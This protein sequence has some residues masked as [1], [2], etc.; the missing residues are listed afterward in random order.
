MNNLPSARRPQYIVAPENCM[1]CG[2][3]AN[4][5]S[6]DAIHMEW[7]AEGFLIPK[8]NTESCIN[9]GLCAKQ[10]IA[11]EEKPAYTDDIE[12]VASW[13]GWNKH[14][15]THLQSSSGGIFTALAE[16]V[17]F[18]GGCVF[19]VVWQDKYTAAF[20]KAE[21]IEELAKMRGSK[22]T[23]AIPG[24]VYQEVLAELKTGRQVLFSGTPCQVH[25]L[26]KFLRKPY[27]N[28]LIIDI[29]CHGVPSR[30][31]LEKYIQE[32]ENRMGKMVAYISFRDKSAGWLRYHVTCHYTDGSTSSTPM[33]KDLYMRLFLCDK[34][35]NLACYNCPYA[36]IPR[37]GD[38]T[39]GDY[40]GVQKIH[41]DWPIDRGISAILANSAKGIQSLQQLSDKLT[42]CEEPFDKIYS[43]QPVVY[44]RHEQQVPR[45]R[46]MVLAR[47]PFWPLEKALHK[48]VN[49]V[50]IG[51]I[52]LKRNGFLHKLLRKC[53][54]LISR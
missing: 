33:D 2:L 14:E 18:A 26:K 16:H 23:P 44:V 43:G 35:L 11:L 24:K 47:L 4:V 38:I 50:R 46:P 37:Q 42:L 20:S 31:I 52:Y 45:A 49:S 21:T 41:P 32:A 51:P 12:S 9:C 54:Q 8:V 36:H 10:C 5:C 53:K 29:M 3:C 27:D 39:L 17:L 40:W 34:A 6:R 19:G 13:G 1:G 15:A 22:Y 48:L 25:A 28:L 30:L 7:S